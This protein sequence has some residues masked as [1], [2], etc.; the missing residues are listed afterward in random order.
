MESQ[1]AIFGSE[2]SAP[3][4][5]SS[6]PSQL[7]EQESKLDDCIDNQQQASSDI[8]NWL[9]EKYLQLFTVYNPFAGHGY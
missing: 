6:A 5:Q 8:S 7:P 1:D 9:G 2:N 3:P 4:G